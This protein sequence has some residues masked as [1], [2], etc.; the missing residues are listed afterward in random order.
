MSRLIHPGLGSSSLIAHVLH[1]PPPHANS[2]V[3]GPAVIK[4]TRGFTVSRTTQDR[5]K[6]EGELKALQVELSEQRKALAHVDALVVQRKRELSEIASKLTAAAE[7]KSA[8]AHE[9]VALGAAQARKDAVMREYVETSDRLEASS[10]PQNDWEVCVCVCVTFYVY[11]HTTIYIY[12]RI[13][14]HIYIRPTL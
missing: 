3:I 9:L 12:I 5:W 14:I 10:E 8:L 13:Y 7:H 6:V 11:I 2:F 4:H 1:S